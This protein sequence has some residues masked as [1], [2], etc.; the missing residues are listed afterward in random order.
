MQKTVLSL[1][2]VKHL[3]NYFVQWKHQAEN[4]SLSIELYEEGPVREQDFNYKSELRNIKDMMKEEGYDGE[5]L[6]GAL[7]NH[8]S[9]HRNL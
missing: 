3:R 1:N 8:E 4:Y 5:D 9:Q 7:K 2:H 6:D